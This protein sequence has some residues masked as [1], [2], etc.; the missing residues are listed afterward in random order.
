M[1][2]LIHTP[3]NDV[4]STDLMLAT[5]LIIPDIINIPCMSQLTVYP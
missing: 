3:Q 5:M 4:W 1:M 2:E